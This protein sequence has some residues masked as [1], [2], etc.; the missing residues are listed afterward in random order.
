VRDYPCTIVDLGELQIV[1]GVDRSW[2]SSLSQPHTVPQA[3]SKTL[4]PTKT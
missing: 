3:I 2:S 1:V 4:A